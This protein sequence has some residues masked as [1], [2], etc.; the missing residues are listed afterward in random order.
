MKINEI[1][2]NSIFSVSITTYSAVKSAEIANKLVKDL[3]EFLKN[4]DIQEAERNI[5]FLKKQLETTSLA[6]LNKVFYGLIEEET[7]R[8]MLAQGKEYFYLNIIDPALPSIQPSSPNRPVIIFIGGL[9]FGLLSCLY[10]I[11]WPWF[12]F[13][14]LQQRNNRDEL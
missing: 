2:E 10:V 12:S 14:F 4:K 1:E 6:G 11:I 13:H 7:K 8:A 5:E 3:D 9:F